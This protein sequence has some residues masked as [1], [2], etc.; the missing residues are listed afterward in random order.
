M[1]NIQYKWQVYC[2][3]CAEYHTTWAIEKPTTCP[4]ETT[5]TLN[6]ELTEKVH[7]VEPRTIRVTEETVP[8]GAVRTNRNYAMRHH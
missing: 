6:H 2:I 3:E 1:S 8:I 4:E 5:H 7:R